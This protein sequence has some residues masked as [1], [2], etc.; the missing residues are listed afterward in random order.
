MEVGDT[1]KFVD[2]LYPDEEGA[3]Y[4]VLEL[5]GDR[6]LIEF[7]CSMPI[8]PRSVANRTELEVVEKGHR[9]PGG[10]TAT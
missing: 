7:I 6:V 2:G 8:P 3:R 1:V 5:N 4:K 10:S 9:M